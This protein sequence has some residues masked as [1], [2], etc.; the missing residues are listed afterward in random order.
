MAITKGTTAAVASTASSA[1]GTV[2]GSWID[3]TAS[4]SASLL[5]MITNTASGPTVG[6]TVRCDLSPDNGTTVYQ[7]V[8][9]IAT[10]STVA[11]STTYYAFPLPP[12]VMYAR[13][14]FTGHT[15]SSVLVQAD[16]TKLTGI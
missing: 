7:G 13:A 6:C 15:G 8:A 2:T 12:D 3:L 4:Y 10:G 1:G 9:G 16:I 11:S 14:V 5:A